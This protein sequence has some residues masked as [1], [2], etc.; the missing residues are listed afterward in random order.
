TP[1][2]LM[3][4]LPREN[5]EAGENSKKGDAANSRQQKDISEEAGHKTKK[6]KR[7]RR[8]PE[9]TPTPKK[10]NKDP[11]LAEVLSNCPNFVLVKNTKKLQDFRILHREIEDVGNDV[12]PSFVM[13]ETHILVKMPLKT[14]S[15][16]KERRGNPM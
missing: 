10:R 11:T 9:Q 4:V 13:P 16:T 1:P 6:A 7:A 12:A 8:E 2:H 14:F 5:Q 15:T 3:N